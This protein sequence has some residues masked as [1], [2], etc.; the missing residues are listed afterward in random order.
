MVYVVVVQ[1]G[2][3]ASLHEKKTYLLGQDKLYKWILDQQWIRT[4]CLARYMHTTTLVVH[5][6][7]TNPP[8][9][10]LPSACYPQSNKLGKAPNV[11]VQQPLVPAKGS[12]LLMTFKTQSCTCTCGQVSQSLH[13]SE[14]SR[15]SLPQHFVYALVY[16][17]REFPR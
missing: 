17:N 4:A 14:Y 6:F 1:K 5:W 10:Y 16:I 2:H 8:H 11:H 13:S 9:H 12:I 7:Q 15:H 3:K